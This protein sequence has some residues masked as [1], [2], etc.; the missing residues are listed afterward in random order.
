M[1]SITQAKAEA[2]KLIKRYNQLQAEAKT[3]DVNE[4]AHKAAEADKLVSQISALQLA[5]TKLQAKDRESTPQKGT[6]PQA[7]A[8][9]SKTTVQPKKTAGKVSTDE[10]KRAVSEKKVLEARMNRLE[11]AQKKTRTQI[12]QLTRAKEDLSRL[13]RKAEKSV[14]TIAAQGQRANDEKLQQEL[15]KRIDKKE[16]EYKTLK[17]EFD[18]VRQ[19]AHK[20]TELLKAQRDTARA[21]LERQKKEQAQSPPP[22]KNKQGFLIIVSGVAT[23]SFILGLILASLFTSKPPPPVVSLSK[24]PAPTQSTEK[25]MVMT[26][27]SEHI[28]RDKSRDQLKGVFGPEMV[29]VPAGSLT[30]SGKN[31]DDQQEIKFDSFY[32]SKYEITFKEYDLFAIATDRELPSDEEWGREQ[33]PV[34]NVSSRDAESYTEWLSKQTSSHYRLPTEEE[35]EYAARGGTESIYWWGSPKIKQANCNNCINKWDGKRTAPVGRFSPNRFKIY[36]TIGN[37]MEWTLSC[38]SKGKDCSKQIVRGSYFRT[39][40][41][42]LNTPKREILNTKSKRNHIGFRIVRI[43]KMVKKEK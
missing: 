41:E 1:S 11:E 12:D 42:E 13:K 34:I 14:A 21:I 19:Q 18:L 31:K 6:S 16:D 30:I 10:I 40:M 35:W 15:A 28:K 32:I 2:Q 20:D 36:D 29:K 8:N 37:V 3:A 9:K 22:K 4:A 38:G 25:A 7:G 24:N 39:P 43:D 23:I 5:I 26:S 33:R 27:R 17:Q